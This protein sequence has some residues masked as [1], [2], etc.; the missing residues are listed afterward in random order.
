MDNIN[1]DKA[2]EENDIDLICKINTNDRINR[3]I[4]YR[5]VF[6]N[7][8][9]I[10]KYICDTYYNHADYVDILILACEYG[11]LDIVKYITKL[12]VDIHT[13][14]DE[15]ICMASYH[16][17]LEIVMYLTK[18]GANINADILKPLR[19]ACTLD[20]ID[21]VRYLIGQGAILDYN[22][23][24]SRY[25]EKPFSLACSNK[26]IEIVQF[27]IEYDINKIDLTDA[28]VNTCI[29]GNV[30]IIK[31]LVDYGADIYICDERPLCEACA[32]D[33]IDVVK[34]LLEIYNG[35]NYSNDINIMRN[36]NEYSDRILD[37]LDNYESRI[38]HKIKR[39]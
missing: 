32:S 6:F 33:N 35:K 26:H 29:S 11:Y 22:G 8:L 10:I 7:N 2:I 37:E 14:N 31:I 36:R 4:L 13:N 25:M 34:Y 12:D 24:G 38:K 28:L 39:S 19:N 16:G 9:N 15:A 23:C 21:I 3:Y 18:I 5:S 20:H 1:I 27:L 17:H 30:D